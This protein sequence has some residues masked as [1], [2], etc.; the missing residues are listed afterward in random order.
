MDRGTATQAPKT[1]IAGV[2]RPRGAAVD[3]GAYEF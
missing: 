1:D 2:A 3:I